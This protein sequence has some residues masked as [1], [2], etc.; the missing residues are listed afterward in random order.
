MICTFDDGFYLRPFGLSNESFLSHDLSNKLV[1]VSLL[2]KIKQINA[3]R[4]DFSIASHILES[5][6]W[7]VVPDQYFL[8]LHLN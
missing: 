8:K 2:G 4:L 5:N 3:L 1:D 7:G 6:A